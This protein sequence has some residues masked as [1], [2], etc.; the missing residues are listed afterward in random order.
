MN[1]GDWIRTKERLPKYKKDGDNEVLVVQ[2]RPNGY[3]FV[4]FAWFT[5]TWEDKSIWYRDDSD[6]FIALEFCPLWMPKPELPEENK[7]ANEA[8]DREREDE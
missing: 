3:A 6:G 2:M 7:L 1:S 8:I 4:T 5:K